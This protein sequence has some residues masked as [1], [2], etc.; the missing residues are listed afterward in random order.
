MHCSYFAFYR[1][2]VKFTIKS[3][4][5]HWLKFID[6]SVRNNLHHFWKYVSNFKRK[7]NSFIQLKV[8]NQYVTDPKLIADAFANHFAST[9]NTNY[10]SII[11]SD[12][13]AS[14]VL[15]TAPIS[16]AEASKAIK[17][18]RPY[19]CVGLD[20][21]PSFII[22]GCSDVF[23][24]LLT[25]RFKVSVTSATFPSLWKQTAVAPVFKKG[26]STNVK[27]YR[28][29]SILNNFSK[30]F[31]FIAHNCLLIFSST[32]LIFLILAFVNSIQLQPV[33]LPTLIILFP[34]FA[35]KFK[36]ILFILT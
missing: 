3:D 7:D 26:D 32:D 11:P 15:P 6:D 10:Q 29:I 18:L 14:D 13:I 21:I 25:H 30:I 16:A 19:K 20:A 22:K 36:L 12:I 2:L 31:E 9:F 1:K 35:L 28:S 27:N 24:P 5:Q 4:R 33:W 17:R 23:V 8:D 34:L